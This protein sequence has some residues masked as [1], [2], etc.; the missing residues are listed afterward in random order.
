MY[1]SPAEKKRRKEFW[2]NYINEYSNNV[3]EIWNEYK[4]DLG[5]NKR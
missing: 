3:K 2:K 5:N 1:Y 4:Y